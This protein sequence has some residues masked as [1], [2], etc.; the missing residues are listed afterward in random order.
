[1]ERRPKRLEAGWWQRIGWAVLALGSCGLLIW[2]PFL[3][4]AIRRGRGSD[5]GAFATLVFY[6]C[7][8]LPWAAVRGDGA[9]DPFLGLVVVLTV[10]LTAGL[11][12][13]GYFDNPTPK[14]PGYGAAPVPPT[15]QGNPYLR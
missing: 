13:F 10:L 3:Y 8:T 11:L 7:V 15:P 14:Q 12:L 6:E 2:V 9:G 1:M 5:W 4:A